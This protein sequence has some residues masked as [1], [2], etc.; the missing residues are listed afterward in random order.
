MATSQ[1]YFSSLNCVQCALAEREL[2]KSCCLLTAGAVD[3]N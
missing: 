2:F 3:V 1:S